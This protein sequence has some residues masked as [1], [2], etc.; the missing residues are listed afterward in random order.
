MNQLEKIAHGIIY[1]DTLNFNIP[2]I[3][4]Q[5]ERDTANWGEAAVGLYAGKYENVHYR[6]DCVNFDNRSTP[7]LLIVDGRSMPISRE[8]AVKLQ[9]AIL[10]QLQRL[11]PRYKPLLP[12]F[13]Y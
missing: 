10:R 5:I 1:A 8:T 13:E 2:T 3:F 9:N 6:L 11:E 7:Y 4:A 12:A